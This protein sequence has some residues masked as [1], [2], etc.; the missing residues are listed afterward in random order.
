V[1][2]GMEGAIASQIVTMQIVHF[3]SNGEET[4][5]HGWLAILLIIPV[6]NFFILLYILYIL[7]QFN[8]KH[9]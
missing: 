3:E 7:T 4:N 1:H 9:D 8:V 5:Q 6:V 2:W